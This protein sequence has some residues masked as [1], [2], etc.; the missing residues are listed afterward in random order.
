MQESTERRILFILLICGV[1]G[2]FI[3]LLILGNII[4]EEIFAIIG[5]FLLFFGM[6]GA[7]MAP[8]IAEAQ[9]KNP[10]DRTD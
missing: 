1:L 2:S 7:L 8:G 10:F 3:W 9:L 6:I 4:P 5:I